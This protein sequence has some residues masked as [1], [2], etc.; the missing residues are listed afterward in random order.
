MY[1]GSPREVIFSPSVIP[2]LPGYECFE[3]VI[4]GIGKEQTC[5]GLIYAP[6]V[7][8]IIAPTADRED[9]SLL[10][11]NVRPV[12]TTGPY[13]DLY[14]VKSP[15]GIYSIPEEDTVMTEVEVIE[16]FNKILR[17][18]IVDFAAARRVMGDDTP[19]SG[20]RGVA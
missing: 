18:N 13:S 20:N 7:A 1:S 2:A 3:P 5:T 19:P 17:S 12:A 16:M 8:W 10:E 14:G 9:G 6:V 15:G 4:E 11:P